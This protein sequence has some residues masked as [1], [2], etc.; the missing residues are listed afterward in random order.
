[1]AL[2]QVPGKFINIALTSLPTITLGLCGI[3]HLFTDP[4]TDSAKVA[5]RLWT[6]AFPSMM[7]LVALA[8]AFRY[9]LTQSKHEEVLRLLKQRRRDPNAR[10]LDPLGGRPVRHMVIVAEDVAAVAAISSPELGS[11]SGSGASKKGVLEYLRYF[12]RRDLLAFAQGWQ[13]RWL[14]KYALDLLCFVG[15]AVWCLYEGTVTF[16]APRAHGG[17]DASQHRSLAA[18]QLVSGCCFCFPVGYCLLQLTGLRWVL[19]QSKPRL[20]AYVNALGDLD[21]RVGD[22]LLPKRTGVGGAFDATVGR[23]CGLPICCSSAGPAGALLRV[24]RHEIFKHS[25]CVLLCTL[26]HVYVYQPPL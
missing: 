6:G 15:Y 18:L 20:R 23:L 17:L 5:M 19:R 3:K 8:L 14:S 16:A 21:E 26:L 22:A 24:S 4:A 1:M 2:A 9:P 12:S 11:S 25:C 10:V 13:N 7:M